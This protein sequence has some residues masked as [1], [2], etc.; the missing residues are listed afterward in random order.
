MKIKTLVAAVAFAT[1]S[2]AAIADS[3]AVTTD[4]GELVMVEKNLTTDMSALLPAIGAVV[5][6][7]IA[8]AGGS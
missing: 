3:S 1:A 7:A 5:L 2:T 8:S 6:I 4:A